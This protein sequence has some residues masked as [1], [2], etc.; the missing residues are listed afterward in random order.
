[1]YAPL[2]VL[3]CFIVLILELRKVTE[4]KPWVLIKFQWL[5]D[6]CHF[7]FYKILLKVLKFMST[8]DS[9]SHILS[10]MYERKMTQ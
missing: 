5:S 6:V 4:Y 10:F 7:L 1:M 2:S 9:G 3:Q 8:S